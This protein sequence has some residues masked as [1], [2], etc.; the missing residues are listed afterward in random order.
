MFRAFGDIYYCLNQRDDILLG[1]RDE[2]ECKEVLK[3]VLQQGRDHGVTFNKE[4]CQFGKEQ[5]EFFGHVFTMKPSPDKV[6]AIKKCSPGTVPSREARVVNHRRSN[7]QRTAYRTRK[8]GHN[9]QH[10]GKTKTKQPLRE[11]YWFPL[12]NS[13][14]DTAINQC[15]ECQVAKKEKREEP[16]KVTNNPS[17]P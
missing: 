6:K 16:I 9:L 4:K 17:H 14:I 10:L 1:G 12:I 7:F 2:V 3:T 15:Y 11:K 8:I 13:M 5:I